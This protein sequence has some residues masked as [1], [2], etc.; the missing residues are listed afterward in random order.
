M[1]KKGNPTSAQVIKFWTAA[2]ESTV[3]EINI[4][5]RW[6]WNCDEYGK[7]MGNLT[8]RLS[9]WIRVC[10]LGIKVS[11]WQLAHIHLITSAWYLNA[12]TH[13]HFYIIC[14]VNFRS[15]YEY[16][17]NI[18]QLVLKL[19]GNLIVWKVISVNFFFT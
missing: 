8:V 13:F 6:T 7:R 1:G 15:E 9:I 12:L 11:T 17:N 18:V 19:E 5:P 4:A 14:S 2:F 16:H 10:L 3:Y